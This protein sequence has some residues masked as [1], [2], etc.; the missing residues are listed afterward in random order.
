M[1]SIVS[2][3]MPIV[4]SALFVFL[5][6]S[7]MHMA[8]KYHKADYRQLPDEARQ[9]EA[10][11]GLPPGYYNFPYCTSMKDMG[12]PEMLD[13]FRRGPVGMLTVLP[14]GPPAMGKYLG[15]WFVYI[16]LVSLF[17][18]YLASFTVSA[19]SDYLAVFRVVGTAAFMAYG[20]ANMVDSIWR[21]LPWSNTIRGTID[22]LIYAL[23]TAGAFGWLWPR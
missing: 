3:W 6:S 19:G 10:L 2:L 11:R 21:G 1:I 8:L 12:S 7:V 22:G 5:V 13:K 20:L 17:S 15:L 23:V 4:V 9:I 18:G 16:L 14:S